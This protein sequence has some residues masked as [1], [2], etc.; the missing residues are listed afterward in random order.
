LSSDQD[1]P[2]FEAKTW[3]AQLLLEWAAEAAL[4]RRP[5]SKKLIKYFRPPYASGIE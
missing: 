3:L 4:H 2:G 1:F 5:E